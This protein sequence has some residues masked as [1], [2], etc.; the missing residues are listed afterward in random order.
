[1]VVRDLDGREA[2]GSDGGPERPELAVDELRARLERKR[3]A[4]LPQGV[5]AA[6]D[7]V[8]GFKHDDVEPVSGEPAGSREPRRPG[9]HDKYLRVA[10]AHAD[11]AFDRSNRRLA[12]A[13]GLTRIV[14]RSRG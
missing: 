8:P 7:P 12:L 4:R 11:L 9:P 3:P 6:A 1:V 2:K 13:A 14:D 5:H 10:T